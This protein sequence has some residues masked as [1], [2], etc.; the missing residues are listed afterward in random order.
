[1]N[2]QRA[3]IVL[4]AL[5][6]DRLV[7]TSE[8]IEELL[9][10]GLA[11]E[12]D[13][14]DLASLH[15]LCAVTREHAGVDVDD[16]NAPAALARVLQQTEEELK[17]DWYRI[18]TS[19]EE[20]ARR[21]TAR[22][23]MRRAL[24]FL[25]DRIALEPLLKAAADARTLAPGIGWVACPALGIEHYALTVKGER[26]ERTLRSRLQRFAETPF[27]KFV[28]TAVKHD[29]KMRDFAEEIRTLQSTIGFVKKNPEQVVIGLAKTGLP[30]SQVIGSYRESM[31]RGVPPAAAVTCARN[32]AQ[33]GN[34][35][36]AAKRL[37]DAEAA[38]LGAGYPGDPVVM[39]A[40]KSL[41]GFE[42]LSKGVARFQAIMKEIERTFG[43]EAVLSTFG[44]SRDILFKMTAR[45]MTA[46]GLPKEV[47]ARVVLT[48]DLMART[49]GLLSLR[50]KHQIAVGLAAMAR[51]PK[52]V[53]EL[54]TR[55]QAVLRSLVAAGLSTS[56]DAP[57]DALECVAC[58][59]TP[60][61]VAETVAALA[62]EIAP[63]RPPR[64]DE[65]AIAV[66]FAKRFAF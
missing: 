2:C 43:R 35:H 23:A 4:R 34:V 10:L 45:L 52:A 1:M 54:V 5:A 26:V 48:L 37:G 39:G 33:F 21:E 31:K 40:A 56:E 11:V 28:L 17:S 9:G 29:T 36:N 20:L 38:L 27:S 22:I 24:A 53:P 6:T 44:H 61:E 3:S 32:A 12:A 62:Q 47:V 64:R 46:S 58:P 60:Q 50:G 41:L 57:T 66:A 65:V 63:G 16:P 30:A 8:E 7:V 18:K 51:D 49:P 15:W 42:P 19:K 25:S 59:G 55:Y 14:E 13:P